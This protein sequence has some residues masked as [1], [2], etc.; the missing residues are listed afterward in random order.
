MKISWTDNKQI[1]NIH[2]VYKD[3][4]AKDWE[5]GHILYPLT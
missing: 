5:Y 4:P 3:E 1:E 2:F